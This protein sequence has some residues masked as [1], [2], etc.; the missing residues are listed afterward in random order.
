[1]I[2]IDFAITG[3]ESPF[4][5]RTDDGAVFQDWPIFISMNVAVATLHQRMV[6]G[7]TNAVAFLH[8]LSAALYRT[9]LMAGSTKIIFEGGPE[10][11]IGAKNSP[12]TISI[13]CINACDPELRI[14]FD[15][16]LSQIFDWL[17]RVSLLIQ[18]ALEREGLS[19]DCI[20]RLG[21]SEGVVDRSGDAVYHV[22][23]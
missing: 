13:K 1:M 20:A 15:V 7:D 12:N 21:V 10:M 11:L 17:R 4:P 2:K 23:W 5:D 19:Y 16:E 6:A 8:A 22:Y 18:G 9:T 3:V 14:E